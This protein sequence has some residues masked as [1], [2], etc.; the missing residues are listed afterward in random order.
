M[1]KLHWLF[2]VAFIIGLFNLPAGIAICLLALNYMVI[3][4]YYINNSISDIDKPAINSITAAIC[5]LTIIN[6][7]IALIVSIIIHVCL[8]IY[9][10]YNNH[11]IK[12]I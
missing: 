5:G 9:L 6:P 3:D 2:Y 11:N 8:Y 1:I 12:F 10:E 7:N 4:S